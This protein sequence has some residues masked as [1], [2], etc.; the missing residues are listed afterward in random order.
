MYCRCPD[1]IDSGSVTGSDWLLRPTYD[2]IA[3]VPDVGVNS[4]LP[5]LHDPI[6]TA[7]AVL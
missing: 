7:R 2:W 1:L 3:P 4:V 5:L 6:R